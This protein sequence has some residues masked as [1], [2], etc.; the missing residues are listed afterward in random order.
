MISFHTTGTT[1]GKKVVFN[2]TGAN[3]IYRNGGDYYISNI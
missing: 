3:I 1:S 2:A